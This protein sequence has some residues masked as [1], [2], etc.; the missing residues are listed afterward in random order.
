MLILAERVQGQCVGLLIRSDRQ[1]EEVS[2][3]RAILRREYGVPVA[4]FCYPAGRYDQRVI[5][6]VKSAGYLAAT[7]TDEGFARPQDTYVLGRVRVNGSDSPSSLL[8]KLT[9]TDPTAAP[10]LR[11]Q[12]GA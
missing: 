6:A 2:G 8:G 3:S 10:T 9:G 11:A 1:P 4:N 7:T 5:A 12:G